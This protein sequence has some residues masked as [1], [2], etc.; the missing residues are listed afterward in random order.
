VTIVSLLVGTFTQQLITIKSFPIAETSL[1]NG[2]SVSP[3]NVP[4]SMYWQNFSGRPSEGRKFWASIPLSP[5][6]DREQHCPLRLFSK[7]PLTVV[8]CR[9]L[10]F[11]SMPIVLR[12]TANGQP[13]RL[14]L[15]AAAALTQPSRYPAAGAP[16][17][18]QNLMA[19]EN[20]L[21]RPRAC[22]RCHLDTL[23]TSPISPR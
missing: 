22:T 21:R 16:S 18:A 10:P 6:T 7:L 20:R 3:G 8:C 11:P 12:A 9:P 15:F 23:Q 4:W 2:F 5:D 1:D 13:H 14:S 19:E 17:S